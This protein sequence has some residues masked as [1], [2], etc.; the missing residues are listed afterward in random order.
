MLQPPK[1]SELAAAVTGLATA[2]T[3]QAPMPRRTHRPAGSF[4]ASCGHSLSMTA[5]I[6]SEIPHLVG[7][8]VIFSI[9]ST[10]LRPQVRRRHD[11]SSL[12]DE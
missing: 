5:R 2:P 10:Y 4:C 6:S 8:N 12:R 9:S 11:V 3:A 7:D 1:G